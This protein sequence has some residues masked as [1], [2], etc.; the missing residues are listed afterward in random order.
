MR[1]VFEDM[2]S[3]FSLGKSVGIRIMALWKKSQFHPISEVNRVKA[4]KDFTKVSVNQDVRNGLLAHPLIHSFAQFT[5]THVA[6][7]TR[8]LAHLEVFSWKDETMNSFLSK[9]AAWPSEF[10]D[11]WGISACRLI[12]SSGTAFPLI[13]SFLTL[14]TTFYHALK[15]R[16]SL[17]KT[18][19][20]H[21][22]C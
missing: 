10:Q 1:F 12:L 2:S 9:I 16:A 19:I 22:M 20:K 13:N 8:S 7:P 15:K 6:L 14:F 4:F 18:V 3:H 21:N 17:L 11:A 5:C